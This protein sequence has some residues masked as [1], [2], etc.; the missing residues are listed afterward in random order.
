MFG[1]S[2]EEKNNTGLKTSQAV[3]TSVFW[4]FHLTENLIYYI[5]MIISVFVILCVYYY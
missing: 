5:I 3:S 2:L 4:S 1:Y